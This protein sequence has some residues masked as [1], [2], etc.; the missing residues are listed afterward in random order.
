MICNR[1]V[2][3]IY[4]LHNLLQWMWHLKHSML[5]LR[6][7]SF[8]FQTKRCISRIS[9]FF[10]LIFCFVLAWSQFCTEI[11]P[12]NFSTWST[13]TKC[14]RRTSTQVWT[15]QILGIFVVVVSFIDIGRDLIEIVEWRSQMRFFVKLF[16]IG[17]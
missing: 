6:V 2:P 12:R 13:T 7:Y 4:I 8:I 5:I 11:R 14:S 1:A 15:W 16:S 3:W 17:I 9:K 10:V